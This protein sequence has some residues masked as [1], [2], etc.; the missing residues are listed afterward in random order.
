MVLHNNVDSH[1]PRHIRSLYYTKDRIFG[2]WL[3]LQSRNVL[4]VASR[5]TKLAILP[6]WMDLNLNWPRNYQHCLKFETLYIAKS[7]G[8]LWSRCGVSPF[9]SARTAHISCCYLHATSRTCS[10]M[11]QSL[12]I[13]SMQVELHRIPYDRFYMGLVPLQ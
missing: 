3:P 8:L 1:I 6:T 4:L 11:V 7:F 13:P 2:S 10:V 9:H 12:H 5:Y